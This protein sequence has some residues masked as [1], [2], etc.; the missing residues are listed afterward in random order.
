MDTKGFSIF[1]LHVTMIDLL[2]HDDRM[3]FKELDKKKSMSSVKERMEE[4]RIDRAIVCCKT[5]SALYMYR[6]YASITIDQSKQHSKNT[7][8]F[9][10]YEKLVKQN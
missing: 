3:L 10:I 4:N 1:V 6:H 9:H 7:Q 5:S 8:N 2:K